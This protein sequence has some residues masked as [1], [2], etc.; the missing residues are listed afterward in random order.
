MAEPQ[1]HHGDLNPDVSY[2]HSDAS[3]R[4]VI[5]FG[6]GLFV[7]AVV[8]Q[9]AVW[10]IF[11]YLA[12]MEHRADKRGFTAAYAPKDLPPAPMLSG[13][14]QQ[15]PSSAAMEDQTPPDGYAWVDR[16][17]QV[18]RVPVERAEAILA[19]RL[20]AGTFG[21]PAATESKP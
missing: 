21:Q 3:V 7:A 1:H 12:A 9:A 6:V 5:W 18:V 15:Q 17:T 20:P 2:E 10:L 11:D 13:L 16:K 14:G 8:I 19:G 4:A